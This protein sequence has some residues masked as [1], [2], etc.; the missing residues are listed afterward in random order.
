[1]R[2]STYFKTASYL[3]VFSAF[4]SLALTGELET[5]YIIIIVLGMAAGF[6]HERVDFSMI[7]R[8]IQIISIPFLIADFFFISQDI[9]LAFTHLMILLTN[10]RLMSLRS[11]SD[12]SQLYLLTFF[13]LLA[14]SA[15]TINLSF[16]FTFTLYLVSAT[17]VLLLFHIKKEAEKEFPK[18]QEGRLEEAVT[19]PFFF[20]IGGVAVLSLAFTLV[21]FFTL[22]RVGVGL[23]SKKPGKALKTTGFADKVDFGSIGPITLDPTTVMR[24]EIP[25]LEKGTGAIYLRGAVLDSFDGV[26]W[27]KERHKLTAIKRDGLD[28]QLRKS[29]KPLVRQEV[30]LD[31]LDSKV[32]FGMP[33]MIRL[34]G[35]FPPLFTDDYDAV[36]LPI[37]PISRFQYT[38]YSDI[39][40]PSAAELDADR[41]PFPAEVVDLYTRIPPLSEEVKG[42]A[43]SITSSSQ[44]TYQKT[45]AIDNYLKEN[46]AYTLDPERDESLP[47]VEDFLLKNKEGYCDHF[48]T[49]M[50]VLLRLQGVPTRLVTGY[51]TTEW[52]SLGR[53]YTVR[54]R[55]A[56]SWV[57]V[58]FPSYGW[59]LFDPTP[60]AAPLVENALIAGIDR[61]MAYVRLKWDRYIINFTLQDQVNAAKEAR[62][63]TEA[64]RD[65]LTRII[66]SLK[67]KAGMVWTP[68]V[69]LIITGILIYLF[70]RRWRKRVQTYAFGE[71]GSV[72][73]YQEMLRI[74][75][76]KGITKPGSMTPREF[77]Q[78][79]SREKG[80]VYSDTIKVSEAFEKVK[81]GGMV[82]AS[83]ETGDINTILE[84]LRK[85]Y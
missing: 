29:V 85:A 71:K 16:A 5:P 82:L 75:A 64:G 21:I 48:S 25:D 76:R 45:K 17:W 42:L 67:V 63:R 15:L 27:K 8:G 40:P 59:I 46:Y 79:L 19:I 61:Y 33:K 23:F 18:G 72:P 78:M 14:A 51:V 7:S 30:I 10:A 77:A 9:L 68:M 80:D 4:L 12:Y 73:F 66:T 31:P 53:F 56:H 26:T 41:A 38:A 62:K 3:L 1:M 55:N 65:A 70:T 49:A 34:S 58:Y 28:F 57:E 44:T 47:P 83:K 2:F 84:H 81:Y 50:A 35:R 39:S 11:N 22:P 37:S 52:N 60:S 6:V 20:G 32:I 43:L 36:Y 13:D 69:I 74:L 54:Q 24:V